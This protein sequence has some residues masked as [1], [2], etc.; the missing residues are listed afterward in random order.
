MKYLKLYDSF[1]QETLEEKLLRFD[2]PLSEWGKGS[3]K[4][5]RHLQK[6]I[7]DKETVLEER[8]GELIRKVSVVAVAVENNGK[9]LVE[10][11]QEFSDGRVRRRGTRRCGEK[12][13]AGE[14]SEQS[15]I[16]CLEEEL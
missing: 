3:A 2:I 9:R 7:D 12:C 8:N 10:D 4:N 1:N 11:R 13:I 14:T 5:I 15:A 6:E 16:R